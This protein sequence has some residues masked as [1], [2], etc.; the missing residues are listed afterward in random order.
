[1]RGKGVQNGEDSF[2]GVESFAP[3]AGPANAGEKSYENKMQDSCLPRMR[4]G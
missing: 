4:E 1:M 3:L 2:A